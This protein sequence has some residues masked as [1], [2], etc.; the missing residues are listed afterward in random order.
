MTKTFSLLFWLKKPR[1]YN[2]GAL[3]IYLRITVNSQRTEF[4]VRRSWEASRWNA[5]HV[6]EDENVPGSAI[7]IAPGS[8]KCNV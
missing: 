8:K 5:A 1:S 7:D 2:K 4:S 3:G 6:K